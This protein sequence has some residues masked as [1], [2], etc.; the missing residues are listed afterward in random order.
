MSERAT[1]AQRWELWVAAPEA[2]G[3]FGDDGA[4][5]P[6]HDAVG[7]GLD[8]HRPADGARGDRVFVLV[9]GDQAGLGD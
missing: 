9:E 5:L 7:I 8:L 6:E 2:G 4:V 1:F 3:M